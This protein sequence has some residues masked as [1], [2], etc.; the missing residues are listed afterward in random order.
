MSRIDYKALLLIVS[1]GTIVI[2]STTIFF[3]SIPMKIGT[4]STNISRLD[5]DVSE[6][7]IYNFVPKGNINIQELD[8]NS[9]NIIE[10]DWNITYSGLFIPQLCISISYII[11]NSRIAIHINSNLWIN[12]IYL[13]DIIILYNPSYNILSF[14]SDS[15]KGNIY[16]KGFDLNIK[17]IYFRTD[18][19][20]IIMKINNSNFEHDFTILTDTGDIDLKLDHLNFSKNFI[21]HSDSGVQL[22]DIWNIRFKSMADFNVSSD[23]GYIRVYWANHFNKSQNVN[24]NIYSNYDTRLKFWCPLEIMRSKVLLSTVD[25]TVQFAKSTGTYEEISEDFYQTIN[26]NDTSLDSYN[27]TSKSTGGHAW[28]HYVN[29]FKWQRDC[30]QAYDFHPYNVTVS[31]NCSLLIQDYDISKINL[32]NT[33]YIYLNETRTLPINYETLPVSSEK[34]LYVEWELDH[35]HAMGI[36]VGALN[37]KITKKLVFDTLLVYV[38]LDFELDRILPRFNECNITVYYHPNY[39]FNHFLL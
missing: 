23:I 17:K 6:V 14:L 26:I 9:N 20:D 28:I 25:G 34:L 4:G 33:G 18:S 29:C 24:I 16:F 15:P 2:F 30:H 36:G 3:L 39:T 1:L 7:E 32:F 8:K 5:K 13:L 38:E 12:Q 27:I 37:L 31:E 21:C 35:I 19:G 11:K 10:I 22:F